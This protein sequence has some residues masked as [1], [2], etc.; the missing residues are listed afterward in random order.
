MHGDV[1]MA[2][3]ATPSPTMALLREWLA[4]RSY[5]YGRFRDLPRLADAKRRRGLSVSLILPTLNVAE[6]LRSILRDLDRLRAGE[7][8]LLDQVVVVDGG[9]IDGT[10]DIAEGAGVDVYQED[11]LLPEFGPA[12]GKGDAMWRALGQVDGD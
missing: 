6:T 2:A 1:S 4:T 10:V 5:P 8:V 11:A 9:S 7:T 12:L 3:P